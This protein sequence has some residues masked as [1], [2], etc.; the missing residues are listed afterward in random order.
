V[1]LQLRRRAAMTGRDAGD[2][3]PWIVLG[4]GNPD[5]EYGNTRHNAGAMVVARLAERAG[6]RLKRSRNRAQVAEIRDG[7]ARVVLARP[8]S[9]VNESGGPASL[10]ARWYKTP[11]ERIIVVHD[12]IDLAYGKLQLRR[13][14]GTAGHNGLKDIAKA[15]GS[16]DF[17][18]VRIGVGRP[19]GRKD[20]AD[21][22][23]EPIAKR[24]AEDF[25]VLV[26]RAADA[27]MDL[28]RLPLE[29]AQDRHNG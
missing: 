6:A 17:L 25:A 24:D 28:V 7:D 16:P 20:P 18:R 19:P 10:L 1:P 14:G 12:E 26:E 22:V 8:N 29:R 21:Y 23:L 9:Y 13:D 5:D 4:L 2:G 11:V 27:T 15:L 3:G